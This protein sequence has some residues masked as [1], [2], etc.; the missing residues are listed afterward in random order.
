MVALK[1]PAKE[2]I[3]LQD[4]QVADRFFAR[5]KGLL[6]RSELSQDQA[7]WIHSCNSIHTF[8]MKFPIDVIFLDRKMQVVRIRKNISPGKIILPVWGASSVIETAA[9]NCEKW[10]KENS[11]QEGDVLH[12]GH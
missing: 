3:L 10:E 5:L 7:L 11:L 4:L 9:G 8:F 6:G 1:N 2:K 12:V